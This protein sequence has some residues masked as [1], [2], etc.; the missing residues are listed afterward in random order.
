MAYRRYDRVR[1]D[2]IVKFLK[3]A[4]S[5]GQQFAA[6]LSYAP[7]PKAVVD[8]EMAQLAKIGIASK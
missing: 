1:G 6:L 2:A 3:W 4:L 7:L 8:K 5:D